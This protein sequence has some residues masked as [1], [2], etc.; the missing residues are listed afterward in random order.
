[1]TTLLFVLLGM[2]GLLWLFEGLFLVAW[3]LV[4]FVRDLIWRD[5]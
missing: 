2:F 5:S 3:S 4:L 1:M